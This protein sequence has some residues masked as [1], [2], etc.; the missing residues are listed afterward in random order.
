M[1]ISIAAASIK[2]FGSL[3]MLAPFSHPRRNARSAAA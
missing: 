1:V 3:L 2:S